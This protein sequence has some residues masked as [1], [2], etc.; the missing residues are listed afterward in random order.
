MPT[1]AGT[2][3]KNKVSDDKLACHHHIDSVSSAAPTVHTMT[4]EGQMNTNPLSANTYLY[5]VMTLDDYGMPFVNRRIITNMDHIPILMNLKEGEHL[6][7]SEIGADYSP[8][9]MEEYFGDSGYWI[10]IVPVALQPKVEQYPNCAMAW[11]DEQSATFVY[12]EDYP[13]WGGMEAIGVKVSPHAKL[14]KRAKEITR[15]SRFHRR[16][17]AGEI[18]LHIFEPGE[19]TEWFD[20]QTLVRPSYLAKLG[21][22]RKD[23]A[24]LREHGK[25]GSFRL[26]TER[27]LIKGDF[28][29]ARSDDDLPFDVVTSRDNLKPEFKLVRGG[30][31][32]ASCFLHHDHHEATTDVQTLSWIGET[33]LPKEQLK[34]ALYNV[35]SDVMSDLREGNFPR[36]MTHSDFDTGAYDEDD[37]GTINFNRTMYD[38]WQRGGRSLNESAYFLHTITT[39]FI[40]QMKKGMKFPIP[41]AV[42]AHVT[43]HELLE[44]AGYKVSAFEGKCFYHEATGRFSLPGELFARLFKNHGGWDL[45]DSVRIIIREFTDG[46]KA[47]LLRSPNAWG[48]YSIVDVDLDSL[49]PVLYNTHGE[50]PKMDMSTSEFMER[51]LVIHDVDAHVTYAGMPEGGLVM[52]DTYSPSSAQ[53]VIDAMATSPGVGPWANSQ[54]VY[55]A[56]KGSFRPAQLA[57]TED[58]VDTLTQSAN[59]AGF[60]AITE[61]INATW[62][63]IAVGGVVEEYFV[64]RDVR[65]PERIREGLTTKRGYLTELSAVHRVIMNEFE[66]RAK[67]EAL[68][69][70]VIIPELMQF[71]VSPEAMEWATKAIAKYKRLGDKAPKSKEFKFASVGSKFFPGASRVQLSHHRSEFFRV[72]NRRIVKHVLDAPNG[73][74]LMIALY[75]RSEWKRLQKDTDGVDRI[76]FAP[77]FKGEPSV[78]D[79]L[80]ATI[81]RVAQ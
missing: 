24:Y 14:S 3:C 66:D 26:T 27:G 45:D 7:P 47:V 64:R 1:K 72:L 22:T 67:L 58:V 30:E 29:V 6:V 31:M 71:Q 15:I 18:T 23:V 53:S 69:H 5:M 55:Y 60:A 28:I 32:W 81:N 80:L 49:L 33:L 48:E 62:Q 12:L 20:G 75:Q 21:Y 78:M 38:R 56:T 50:I 36:Y 42:Y 77:H 35:A 54:M 8:A 44:M 65:V 2:P 63:E 11:A 76:L 59:P 10:E 25:N 40:N 43:T 79:L 52:E 73:E 68:E 13:Y 34:T 16:F 41:H 61:D 74:E 57:H 70:R 19:H 51:V 39:G 37:A 4:K 9:F 17:A 46:I